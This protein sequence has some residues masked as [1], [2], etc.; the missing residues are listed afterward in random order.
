MR[1]LYFYLRFVSLDNRE[2]DFGFPFVGRQLLECRLAVEFK[3]CAGNLIALGADP[4]GDLAVCLGQRGR[5]PWS[6]RPKFFCRMTE[7]L[8]LTRLVSNKTRNMS[9]F[10][11]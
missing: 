3:R 4:F 11:E 10:A 7:K 9:I 1:A 8:F 5:L 2:E 6:N